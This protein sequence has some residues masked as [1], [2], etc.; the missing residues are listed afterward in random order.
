MLVCDNSNTMKRLTWFSDDN[1][2]G[3][4]STSRG[5]Q[6]YLNALYDILSISIYCCTGNQCPYAHVKVYDFDGV[7]SCANSDNFNIKK[8]GDYDA[9]SSQGRRPF[10]IDSC[11]YIDWVDDFVSI[12]RSTKYQCPNGI[13]TENEYDGNLDCQGTISDTEQIPDRDCSAYSTHTEIS[14]VTCDIA[15]DTC[16]G[17]YSWPTTSIPSEEPTTAMTS[18]DPTM[19]SGEPTIDPTIQPSAQPTTIPT[20]NPTVIPTANPSSHPTV[21]PTA[22][23]STGTVPSKTDDAD[24]E[25][26]SSRF[27][28]HIAYIWELI[29]I[30]VYFAV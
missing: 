23:P 28:F 22:N 3:D 17:L 15:I 20:T 14:K 21:E 16:G 7:A 29:V 25:S 11:E 12:Y 30:L 27:Q 18:V 13:F 19:P 8:D 10:V 5:M 6:D 9:Y 1:C 24:D 4:Y 2:Q 26:V